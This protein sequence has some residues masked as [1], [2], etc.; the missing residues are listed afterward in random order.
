[1]LMSVLREA[2]DEVPDQPAL[3]AV[4]RSLTYEACLARSESFASGLRQQGIERLGC[5]LDDPMEVLPLL[6]GAS[7]APSEAC[8]YPN[9]VDASAVDEYAARFQHSWVITDRPMKLENATAV[10]ISDLL[11]DGRARPSDDAERA[12]LLVLTTGTTGHQRAARHDWA[13][14]LTGVAQTQVDRVE[15]WLVAYNLNQFG[16]LQVLLHALA[17]RGTLT[18]ARSNQPRDVIETIRALA[19]THASGTPTFW[20]L[21][22]AALSQDDLQEMG[23]EQITLGGEAVSQQLLDRLEELFPEARICH[24]YGATEFGTAL[25]VC[26]GRSGLP[27]SVLE[28]REGAKVQLRIVDGEL[29]SRSSVRMLGYHGDEPVRDEWIPTGDL[30]EVRDDRIRFVGRTSEI[31]NVGGAKVHPLPV[32]EVIAAVDGVELARV[33]GRPNPI[34]GQL[35]VA[36]VV[37]R[38]EVDEEQ[39]EKE[40]RGACEALPRAAR[41]RRIEFVDEIETRGSKLARG[42]TGARG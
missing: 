31:I 17:T 2:A 6:A 41:P 34:T 18:F 22:T 12:S 25:S 23:L 40:I 11:A 27:I 28:R 13:R 38:P 8:V 9:T 20:R 36:E 3:A 37:S 19:V 30:V 5:V 21:F 1:M 29:H 32:E 16:G 42:S 39:L 14:L 35:A 33:Y 7:A 15:R 24:I 10:P 26:D 4:G